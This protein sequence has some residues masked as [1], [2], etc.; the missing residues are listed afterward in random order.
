MD[1][2][3]MAWGCFMMAPPQTRMYNGMEA[4]YVTPYYFCIIF[5]YK[6]VLYNNFFNLEMTH[7]QRF[8]VRLSQIT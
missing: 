4:V 6:N 5:L 7:M 3:L 1:T 8:A 2:M